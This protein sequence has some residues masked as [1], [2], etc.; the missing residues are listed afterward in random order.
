[1]LKETK[2]MREI[3]LTGRTK[4]SQISARQRLEAQQAGKKI[5]VKLDSG[6]LTPEDLL[7]FQNESYLQGFGAGC[8]EVYGLEM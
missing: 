5:L 8:Y 6:T 1:M 2:K 4:D 7:A 3:G